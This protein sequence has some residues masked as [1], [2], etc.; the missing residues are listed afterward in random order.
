VTLIMLER[1]VAILAV[2]GGQWAV[3]TIFGSSQW[4][5]SNP[6]SRLACYHRQIDDAHDLVVAHNTLPCRSSVLVYN[7]RTKKSVLARVGDRGPR[8]AGIDLSRQVARHLGHNGLETV[9]VVS[10]EAPQQ[11]ADPV[12]VAGPLQRT[13]ST[14]PA[15]RPKG[16]DTAA[17]RR[18]LQAEAE[19]GRVPVEEVQV[20]AEKE[21]D[22][23]KDEEQDDKDTIPTGGASE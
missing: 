21:G 3:G 13:D 18:A 22:D 6:N 2:L 4:D 19:S 17:L 14:G 1:V 12:L 16:V 7:P 5:R 23:S 9:L 15:R 8:R 11:K 20:V 10:L